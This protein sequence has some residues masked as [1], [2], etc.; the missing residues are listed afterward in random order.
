[1]IYSQAEAALRALTGSATRAKILL[2]LRDGPMQIRPLSDAVGAST[3]TV[4]H[5]IAAMQEEITKDGAAYRLTNLG[6]IRAEALVRLLSC[7]IALDENAAFWQSHDISGIPASLQADIGL[8]RGANLVHN[9]T[10]DPLA[11]QREFLAAIRPAKELYGISSITAPGY[12]DAICEMLARD[13]HVE[14]ILTPEVI[15]KIPTKALE[16]AKS[17]PNFTLYELPGLKM[18]F[19]VTESLSSLA[20]HGLDGK[21]DTHQD[22]IC[23]SRGA[24]EWGTRLFNHYK[25]LAHK[26]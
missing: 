8:L 22:L 24:V 13:A 5:S 11:S 20:L 2:A 14:L 25:N 16:S 3:S 19:S 12:Q 17:Y 26:I 1:M 18:G 9:G 7:L 4:A 15:A 10:S 23:E 21:Y 6:L